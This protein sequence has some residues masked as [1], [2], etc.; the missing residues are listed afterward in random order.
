VAVQPSDV[1]LASRVLALPRAFLVVCVNETSEP[2]QRRVAADGRAFWVPIGAGRA[3]L[4]L[5]E[6]G[7][8]RIL[9]ATPG[10]PV[11]PAR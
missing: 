1:P 9:A 4:V 11:R 6:S 8:G 2:A 10:D 5:V 7:T 3:R